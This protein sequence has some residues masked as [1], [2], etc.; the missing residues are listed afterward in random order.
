MICMLCVERSVPKR[1]YACCDVIEGTSLN[2][3]RLLD[4]KIRKLFHLHS[5]T[6]FIIVSGLK[7]SVLTRNVNRL[8]RYSKSRK[9]HERYSDRSVDFPFIA[10]STRRRLC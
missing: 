9:F 4:S 1:M 8:K 7:S 5:F 3:M 6:Y 10:T 2:E